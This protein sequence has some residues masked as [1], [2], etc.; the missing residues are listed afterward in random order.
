MNAHTLQVSVRDN[1]LDHQLFNEGTIKTSFSVRTENSSQ[2][3][4]IQRTLY[5]SSS[6]FLFIH[7][8]GNLI[9]IFFNEDVQNYHYVSVMLV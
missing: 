8:V 1:I 3:A 6:T 2:L 7:Q 4:A 5:L 9:P